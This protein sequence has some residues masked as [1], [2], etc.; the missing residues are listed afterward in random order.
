MG[1]GLPS[2]GGGE[3]W[4]GNVAALWGAAASCQWEAVEWRRWVSSV[5]VTV[6]RRR[7]WQEKVVFQRQR[8]L[9]RGV[10]GRGLRAWRSLVL[11]AVFSFSERR[12]F[13]ISLSDC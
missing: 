7:M 10:R 2:A 6:R 12:G 8:A 13:S 11:I 4:E 5:A 1:V 9:V 3:A